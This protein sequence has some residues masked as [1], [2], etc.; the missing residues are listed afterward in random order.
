M[1]FSTVNWLG[2]LIAFLAGFVASFIWFGPKT[3]YPMWWKAMG[4]TPGEQ[5]GSSNMGVVFGL[6]AAAIFAS[7]LVMELLI[8]ATHTTGAGAGA[9]LGLI[10]GIGIAAAASLGHRLFAA[11]GLKVWAI[12]VGSDVLN[13]VLMGVILGAMH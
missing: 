12:E 8:D 13:L 9:T 11:Q 1:D 2:V 4:K 5:P 6:T 3:F 10:V 7:A